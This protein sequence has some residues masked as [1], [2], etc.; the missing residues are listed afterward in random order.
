MTDN[1]YRHDYAD[2]SRLLLATVSYRLPDGTLI[3][4]RG[5][6]PDK[7][8]DIEWWRFPIE[9]DPQVNV[10]IDLIAASRA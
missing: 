2:G 9:N 8:L 10:A 4:G 5:I 3:E 1:L 7:V 6:L